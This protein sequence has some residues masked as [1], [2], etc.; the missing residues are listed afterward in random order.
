[1][2]YEQN[3]LNSPELIPLGNN[4]YDTIP[5][6]YTKEAKPVFRLGANYRLGQATYLRTSWGQGYRYPTI[7][8][9]FISTSFSGTNSVEP[10]VKLVSETGWSA[11]LGLKQG[12]RLGTWQ[13]FLDL[14]AFVQEYEN[15]MEFVFVKTRFLPGQGIGAIFQSQNQG[16]TRVTGGEIAVLGQGKLGPGQLSLL[17]GF[18]SI[19]PKYKQFDRN[20][21]Y[22]PSLGEVSRFWGSSDTTQNILK[23]RFRHTFKWDSEYSWKKLALGLSVQ[24]NSNM[25]SVDRVFEIFLPG[26]KSFRDDHNTGFTIV[27]VRASYKL[28]DRLKVSAIAANLLNEVY[29]LRPA[30]LEAPRSFTVRLDW[31]M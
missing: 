7:A 14:A 24:Y 23:Y 21:G 16:N 1:V 30:L 19:N 10:N 27:D 13:G 22:N 3:I 20:S 31:K 18:T 8:E 6:G 9:K 17:A 15:M 26:V 4:K 29:S 28:T 25:A 11:E 5:G 2:R 12:F